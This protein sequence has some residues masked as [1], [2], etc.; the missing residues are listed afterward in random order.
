MPLRDYE[1]KACDH[2][3][4]DLQLA[5][6]IKPQCPEC[7]SLDVK[8]LVSAHGGYSMASGPSSI[9]PKRAGSFKRSK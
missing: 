4:E 5:A 2:K 1:C 3:F 7:N 8:P 6:D 9:R